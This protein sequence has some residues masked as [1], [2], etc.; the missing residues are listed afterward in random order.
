[1]EQINEL[2][3]ELIDEINQYEKE[4]VQSLKIDEE[5]SKQL[6]QTVN[7]LEVFHLKWSK[8]LRQN[9]INDAV[10]IEAN[11]SANQ[12]NKKA[13][14]GRAKLD[15]LI[16]NENILKFEKNSNRLSASILGSLKNEGV[17]ENKNSI[18]SDLQMKDL[19]KLCNFSPSQNLKLIYRASEHG[20]AIKN[21]HLNCD[22]QPNTFI[23]IKTT[24]R[25]VFGG[26]TE[27]DWSGRGLGKWKTDQN[28]FLFSFIKKDGKPII[29]KCS[30]PSYA[31]NCSDF[32]IQFGTDLIIADNSNENFESN[33]DIGY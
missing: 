15:N 18:L 30:K 25:N 29:L 5:T 17:K 9:Q 13:Q 31:I 1:M 26:F 11:E 6:S 19:M 2:N 27:Q 7:E 33:S 20:F 22:N 16:F 3:K 10:I 28:A 21:F 24:N 32:N 12:L 4:Q 14:A 23:I 8:Y